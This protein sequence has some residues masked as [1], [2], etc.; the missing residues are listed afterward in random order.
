M[1]WRRWLYL[2]LQNWTHKLIRK[3]Y[4]YE[5]ASLTQSCAAEGFPAPPEATFDQ[6]ARLYI[7][8]IQVCVWKVECPVQTVFWVSL[9]CLNSKTN[10]LL[11][12]RKILSIGLKFNS[13][14]FLDDS[15]RIIAKLRFD[16]QF[17]K[18]TPPL[19]LCLP[20]SNEKFICEVYS[21]LEECY[22]MSTHPQKRDHQPLA[23]FLKCRFMDCLLRSIL[24]ETRIPSKGM[25]GN[26]TS[27]FTE[28][29]LLLRCFLI[30]S[31]APVVSTSYSNCFLFL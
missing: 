20:G 30:W 15:V 31:F 1:L 24:N 9:S 29:N 27:K 3:T 23:N 26:T 28:A 13:K 22:S 12:Y 8:Y 2:L 14:W 10:F 25:F 19:W 18:G 4:R 17:S 7:R 5:I 16:F 11:L 21:S 6:L